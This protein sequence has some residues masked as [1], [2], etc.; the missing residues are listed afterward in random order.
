MNQLG[1]RPLEIEFL[2]LFCLWREQQPDTPW[3][4]SHAEYGRGF[5]GHAEADRS[6]SCHILLYPMGTLT[7]T[8]FPAKDSSL[9]PIAKIGT[10]SHQPVAYKGY[11]SFYDIWR[12]LPQNVNY[13]DRRHCP[14][15]TSQGKHAIILAPLM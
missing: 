7:N 15:H 11:F 3:V 8:S 4:H 14:A 12:H 13:I 9:L 10:A 2:S 5:Y 6:A 1:N